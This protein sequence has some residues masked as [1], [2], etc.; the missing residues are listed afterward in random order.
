MKLFLPFILV[1]AFLGS[2]VL[3]ADTTSLRI[4]DLLG[5]W[6][7]DD[8]NLDEVYSCDAPVRVHVTPGSG[9]TVVVAAPDWTSTLKYREGKNGAVELYDPGTGATRIEAVKYKEGDLEIL[10]FAFTGGR[11]DGDALALAP[12][13]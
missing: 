4:D 1:A 3:A 5:D 13:Y 6:S 7:A 9:L 8:I 12:C 11:L 2:P 10:Q